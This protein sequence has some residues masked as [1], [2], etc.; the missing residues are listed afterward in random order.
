MFNTMFKFRILLTNRENQSLV[1]A[2]KQKRF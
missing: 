2:A 1:V